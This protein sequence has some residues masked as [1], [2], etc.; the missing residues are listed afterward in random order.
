MAR[1]SHGDARTARLGGWSLGVLPVNRSPS[2]L[3][4][5]VVAFVGGEVV[6]LGLAA[7]VGA[8]A[9]AMG[10]GETGARRVAV[11]ILGGV[12]AGLVE[13]SAV[14]WAQWR[15]VRAPFPRIGRRAWIVAT[16][17]GAALAWAIGMSLGTLV[18]VEEEPPFAVVIVLA[19]LLGGG[20]GALLGAGQWL[21]LRR[22]VRRSGRWVLANALGWT[23]GMVVAFGGSA[24]VGEGVPVGVIALVGALTGAA[25]ALA[26]AVAT[27]RAL[28]AF[29]EDGR[30]RPLPAGG[31]SG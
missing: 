6:G 30:R 17:A 22:H 7:P 18:G 11:A 16:A 1:L 24:L 20:L 29:A 15:V 9:M 12:L 25:M 10:D 28:L 27:G 2:L 13:G 26:P 14:G 4:R 21:V 3:R 19:A 23:A 5:W 31:E 8:A